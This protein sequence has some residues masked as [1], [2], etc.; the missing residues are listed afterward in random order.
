MNPK[1]FESPRLDPTDE[2]GVDIW[3]VVIVWICVFVGNLLAITPPHGWGRRNS[4][5]ASGDSAKLPAARLSCHPRKRRAGHS[6]K[7]TP[8]NMGAKQSTLGS[9]DSNEGSK[10]K[11]Q[12]PDGK[13]Y[14]TLAGQFGCSSEFRDKKKTG[15]KTLL[16]PRGSVR[17][18]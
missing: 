7:A 3:F 13:R 10:N 6:S 4:R 18:Q 17:L 15:R 2:T 5:H 8:P 11:K 9:E 1:W 16:H 14:C 12:K